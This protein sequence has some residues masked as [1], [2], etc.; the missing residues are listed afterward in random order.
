MQCDTCR[1]YY[2]Y[3][4]WTPGGSDDAMKSVTYE[5]ISRIGLLDVYIELTEALEVS[6]EHHIQYEGNNVLNNL[7]REDYVKLEKEARAHLDY[8]DKSSLVLVR[9]VI[10][11]LGLNASARENEYCRNDLVLA[12][13]EAAE[14]LVSFLDSPNLGK[15]PAD[16]EKGLAELESHVNSGVTDMIRRYRAE[17]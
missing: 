14:M 2:W 16:V 9:D 12:E 8:I 5:S 13:I 15:K 10:E 11:C 7:Y 17:G 6:R 4:R 3:R 1:A